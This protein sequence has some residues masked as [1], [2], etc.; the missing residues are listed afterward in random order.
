VENAKVRTNSEVRKD[1][2]VPVTSASIHTKDK[3]SWKY[4]RVEV[5]AKLPL[6][7]GTWPAIWMMP[8]VDT[9]GY[10]PSSGEIDIMEHVGYMPEQV[11]F[12]LHCA[13]YNSGT[14]T[15]P[16]NHS[17][18]CYNVNTQFHVYAVEWKEDQ[19]EFFVDG[20]LKFRVKKKTTDTWREW[21]FYHPFYLILN[22]GFG[23]SWGGQQGINLAGLPQDYVIDYVRVFQ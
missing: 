8:Q 22:S 3:A 13:T 10:W 5:R 15:N 1:T 6:C 18:N 11:H 12:T 21:P 9:Y 20:L 4:C 7:L 19:I 16:R 2:I 23:G 17:V 14:A